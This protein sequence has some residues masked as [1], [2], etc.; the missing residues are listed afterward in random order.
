MVSLLSY[1]SGR[2]TTLGD[3]PDHLHE[4]RTLEWEFTTADREAFRQDE[5]VS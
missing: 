5:G 2:G 3:D 4:V 1:S